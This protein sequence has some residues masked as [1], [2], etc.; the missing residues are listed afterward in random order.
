MCLRRGATIFRR[1]RLT[2]SS[3]SLLNLA[4]LDV[5]PRDSGYAMRY[6]HLAPERL[7]SAVAV[8]DDIQLG[9]PPATPVK[10]EVRA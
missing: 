1:H 10:D 7:R 2:P 8:L 5:G 3:R 4:H 6:A 9:A